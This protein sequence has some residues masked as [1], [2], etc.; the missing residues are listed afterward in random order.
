M[1]GSEPKSVEVD[2][3]RVQ[4]DS[5][6]SKVDKADPFAPV[7][8]YI[9]VAQEAALPLIFGVVLA[10]IL[11][12]ASPEWYKYNFTSAHH[13]GAH[14]NT[15]NGTH[16]MLGGGGGPAV[17]YSHVKN[18]QAEQCFIGCEG[19]KVERMLLVP[20]PI[21]GHPVTLHFFANDLIMVFHFGLAVKEVTEALLPGGSLNPPLKAANPMLATVGGV[22]GPV[23]VFFV[24]L[25]AMTKAGMFP[26]TYSFGE[27]SKGWGIVTATDIPLA[28]LAALVVYGAGHPA[29]DYLLLLAVADDAL[30]MVIIAIFYTDP[31][32]PVQPQWLL[33][34]VFAMILAYV[35][36]KWHYRLE[37]ATHQSWIP[38]VLIC[39]TLSWIG[40]IK[41]KLHPALAL[42]PIVP[43]MPGP[44]HQNLESLDDTVE[45]KLED[46]AAD[47]GVGSG[48][49]SRANSSAGN[50]ERSAVL[51][52]HFNHARGRGT[53]IQAGL[54][55]GL[56]G[57][58][59]PDSLKVI[60]YDEDGHEHLNA[61][62]LDEFEHFW[63]VYVDFGLFL[64][65]LCNAGVQIK[66]APGG[67]T[68]LILLSLIIG[69]YCGIMFFFKVSKK[70]LNYPAPLGIRTRHIRMIGLIA[71]LGL[72]VA[73]FVSDVAFTDDALKDDAR[74]GALLSGFV[75]F[76][77]YAI[78]TK[79]DFAA[80]DVE[81]EVQAQ[82]AEE[83][84]EMG[85]ALQN[86]PHRAA[87]SSELVRTGN[88]SSSE[89]SIAVKG[90][91]TA[92]VI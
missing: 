51:E 1:G 88:S 8:H 22:L 45:E 84:K 3:G 76:A 18:P 78:S 15:G 2:H 71:S 86:R 42:V 72:T 33:L 31:S 59:V 68:W 67:M 44:S 25:T 75:G 14:E 37:R 40:L 50:E 19:L 63:K 62:T 58:S 34:V 81:K 77:C 55:A 27:L 32:S 39:G 4:V 87:S 60:E 80:E 69:K 74:L 65:A 83:M 73:L 49:Q 47:G 66:G 26:D 54:Y 57:H 48:K 52:E 70:C 82:I 41:A 91:D 64:F 53:T 23:A 10:M 61:S 46:S 92:A 21:F 79:F 30:G 28:W 5:S 38:Y 6:K 20:W 7:F 56:V 29:I 89:T 16:R 13:A 9:E 24:A 35:F 12:N 43:F 36:R 85:A 11:A 90:N 17:D